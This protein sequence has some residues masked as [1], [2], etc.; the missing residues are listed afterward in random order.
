M[1]DTL[2][3][4]EKGY[5]AKYKLDEEQRFKAQCRRAKLFGLWAAGQ[6]R[7]AGAQAEAYGRSLIRLN[8]DQPTT[9]VVVQTVL[10]DFQRR[11]VTVMEHQVRLAFDRYL[12][13]ALEQLAEEY[14]TALDT[15][16]V[17]VGD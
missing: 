2:R 8:I 11:D 9:D 7:M 12:A 4:I 1:T 16:H 3:E 17:R 10:D 6:M 13:I 5:E 15:D 14:P